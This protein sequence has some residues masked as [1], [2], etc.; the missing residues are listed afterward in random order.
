MWILAI[1]VIAIVV[2]AFGLVYYWMSP[3]DDEPPRHHTRRFHPSETSKWDS[4]GSDR[5]S[6]K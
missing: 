4:A 5:R 6:A 2:F 1:S 3:A